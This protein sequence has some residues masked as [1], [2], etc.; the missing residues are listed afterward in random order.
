MIVEVI[1]TP[2]PYVAQ[3]TVSA[4]TWPNSWTPNSWTKEWHPDGVVDA[5][6]GGVIRDRPAHIGSATPYVDIYPVVEIHVGDR[7]EISA[8]DGLK[9]Q[10]WKSGALS[11]GPV[12]E[13]R[14]AFRDHL[15]AGANRVP[16]AFE[17]GGY[18]A[19]KTPV[20]D[21]ET[22]LRRALSGY[23]GWSGDVAF[24]TGGYVTPRLGI[25]L[26]LRGDWV[27]ANYTRRYFD[28]HPQHEAIFTL[29]HFGPGDYVTGGAQLT[30]GYRLTP[31]LTAFV[32]GSIDRIFGAAW[33]S[34]ALKTRNLAIASVGMTWHF[35]P[36]VPYG[37]LEDQP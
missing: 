26:E 36:I 22:R 28:I 25:G 17:G 12:L 1:D 24:D 18:V 35:G 23:E 2:A 14:E 4:P 37:K 32:Q 6:I 16:D 15:P 30:T 3:A 34:P 29:P 10:A 13:Y 9:Y 19:L 8:D 5:D 21:L 20:G 33:R 27:D 11:A 7:L 31:R